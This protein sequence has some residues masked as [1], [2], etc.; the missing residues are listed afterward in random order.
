VVLHLV[1]QLLSVGFN[2]FDFLLLLSELVLGLF[3]LLVLIPEPVDLCLQ[4]VRLLFLNHLDVSLGDFLNLGETRVREPI[5]VERNLCEGCVF[6]ER[7]KQ[8]G[9]HV[10]G[11]EIIREF[12]VRNLPISLEGVD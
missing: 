3:E 7:L 1:H 11:K 9:L 6:I 2:F 8:N 12:N 10:L 4:L 5:S